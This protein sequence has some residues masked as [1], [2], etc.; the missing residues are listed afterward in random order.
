M[1]IARVAAEN[2]ATGFTKD[3]ATEANG[4]F[5]ISLLPV[6]S[7]KLTV[8]APH[9]ATLI[10]Q[11]VTVN[12]SQTLRVALKLQLATVTETVTVTSDAPLVDDSTNTLGA[13]VTGREILA[14]PLNG[15]NFAQL[16]LLQS[17]AAPLTSGLIEA[18]GPMRQGQTYAV[19]G[20]RPEENSYIVDG[21]RNLNRMDAGYALKIPVDAIAEF[22][23]LTQ[24]APPEY[25][26]TAGATTAVITRSGGNSFH[27]DLYEFLRNN[28]L[29]TRN[30]FSEKVEPL[31][32]NQFGGTLGGPIWK[33]KLFFFLYYEGFR[34]RQ[35]ETTSST[36]PNTQE[37]TGDFSDLGAPLLNFA[38]GGTEF[39]GDR[40]PVQAL[41][42]VALN[43]INLYPLPNAG[44]NVYR[45]TVVAT[46]DYD[47]AGLRLD[48]NLSDKD[49]L[50]ARYSFS[51]GY[52]LNP[53]S[54]RGTTIPG[55]P[56]RDDIKAHSAELS[57]TH[58]FS[59]SLTNSA[60]IAF[61]RY[62]FDFDMRLNQTPPSALGFEYPSSNAAGQG[63]PF[64]NVVGYSPVGGAITGPRNSVQ[65]SY[66]GE[67]N[68]SWVKG[69]HS[70]AFGAQFIRTQ[71]NMFQGIAPN[72]FFVFAS[73]FPASDAIANLL[74]GAPVTFYQ[75]LGNFNRGLRDWN[76]GLYAQDEW[77]V[78]SH[79][80]FNYGVRYERINPITEIEN[81]LNAFV[82]GVQSVVYPSAPAGLLFPGDPGIGAGIA[83]GDN[84][85][86]P[87]IGF[88]WDPTGR[89][90]WAVRAGYG[91]FYDQFQNG[92][93]TA[94]QVPISALPFAQ[95]VQFGGVNLNFAN[96][97]VGHGY[98][99]PDSF[100]PPSTVF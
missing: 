80:T 98:P 53:V 95:F 79:L 8:S 90:E 69:A 5:R 40:I 73:T 39:P 64:F 77:R 100:V 1:V 81:R 57:S 47:Q 18:G 20:A 96:P 78:T 2:L 33:D 14:L 66:Q 17:G 99:A 89:G 24:T 60:R 74:L 59:P 43:V 35:G 4:F 48:Y 68:L 26:G 63:P 58:T 27:G 34:N 41:N 83:Q 86:M 71:L 19:N 7:Y 44:G 11:P 54:I 31:H 45:T 61:L 88:A 76:L 62:P 84:A 97:Y 15:R 25:G 28:D 50:F 93:G 55:F 23:I 38:A 21:A 12:V 29:D 6:G 10:R 72:A 22:R 42:P 16:G 56:T 65:N 67:E 51:G 94:S 9:F 13:V 46:N 92:A 30:F 87:R 36:V 85:L 49:Q 82:P 75:G 70:M 32:Q 91:I 3:A 37:R 52:D